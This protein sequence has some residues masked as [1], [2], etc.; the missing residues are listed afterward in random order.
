MTVWVLNA[1]LKGDEKNLLLPFDGLPDL[2]SITSEG[3][4]R[5]LLQ[6]LE[7]DAPPE[8]LVRRAEM[9]WLQYSQ[10][11]L[12]DVIV[13]PIH[14]SWSLAQV[15]GGYRYENGEHQLPVSWKKLFVKWHK[16]AMLSKFTSGAR[17]HMVNYPQMTKEIMAL[18]AEKPPR[19]ARAKWAFGVI[20]V[21][22]AIVMLAQMLKGH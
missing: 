18:A 1:E 11:A 16:L 4:M 6:Q 10:L 19:F 17:L 12:G 13:V 9:L 14:K 20:M 5:R 8:T 21:L 7:P 22:N 15:N 3:A 2:S